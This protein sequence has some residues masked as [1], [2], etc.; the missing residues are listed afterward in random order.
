[1]KRQRHSRPAASPAERYPKAAA[2]LG[3]VKRCFAE[4]KAG[5]RVQTNWAGPALTH[6]AFREEFLKALHK[7]IQQKGNTEPKGRKTSSEYQINLMRDR[8]SIAAKQGSRIRMYYIGTPEL[9]RR[10]AH[11]IDSHHDC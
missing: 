1:M 6:E 9:K 4:T 10:F 2:Y 3:W 5:R 8:Q 11:L 7:R